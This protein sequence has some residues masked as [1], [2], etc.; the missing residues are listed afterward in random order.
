MSLMSHLII[1]F[2]IFGSIILLNTNVVNN[3][4]CFKQFQF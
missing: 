3:M 2:C 1:Y 4:V